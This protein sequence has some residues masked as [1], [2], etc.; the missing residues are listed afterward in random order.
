MTNAVYETS[1]K[2]DDR[3]LLL[4]RA[5][6]GSER[7]PLRQLHLNDAACGEVLETR[8]NR[9]LAELSTPSEDD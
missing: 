2:Y 6:R 8:W 1:F 7:P 4:V 9:L 3:T 5:L